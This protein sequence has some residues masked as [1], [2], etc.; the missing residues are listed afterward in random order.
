[1]SPRSIDAVTKAQVVGQL[2]P[3]IVSLL[4]LTLEGIQGLLQLTLSNVLQT[5][6]IFQLTVEENGLLFQ[7]FYFMLQS[8]IFNLIGSRTEQEKGFRDIW[9]SNVNH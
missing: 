5:Q 8:F 4:P 1:M 6:R 9:K 3:Q 7:D 2:F